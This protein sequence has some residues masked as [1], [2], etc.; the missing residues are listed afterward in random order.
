MACIT[1]KFDRW[2]G[3]FASEASAGCAYAARTCREPDIKTGPTW[4]PCNGD[5]LQSNSLRVLLEYGAFPT[6]TK[7]AS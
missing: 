6:Q 1:R 4:G 7:E 2:T 5:P 3:A